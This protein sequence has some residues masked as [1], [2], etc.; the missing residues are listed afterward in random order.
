MPPA[1]QRLDAGDAPARNLDLGLVV[2]EKGAIVQGLPDILLERLAGPEFLVHRRVVEP[3]VVAALLLRL[4]ERQVG[5]PEELVGVGVVVRK[6]RD[7]DA[8]AREHLFLVEFERRRDRLDHPLGENGDAVLMVEVG[9]DDGELV[10][11]EPRHG[12]GLAHARQE[13]RGHL[14]Q[15]VVARR[16]SQRVVDVLEMV[17]VE[18]VDRHHPPGA[19]GVVERL[20]EPDLEVGAVGKLGEGVVVRAFPQRFLAFLAGF[21]HA[22]ERFGQDSY[23]VLG[24]D[25]DPVIELAFADG[26]RACDQFKN[27]PDETA[28]EH[29]RRADAND[30]AEQRHRQQE[31]HGKFDRT[32]RLPVGKASRHFGRL[33]FAAALLQDELGGTY[34]LCDVAVDSLGKQMR[35]GTRHEKEKEQNSDYQPY[36]FGNAGFRP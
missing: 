8:G 29:D 31:P 26:F 34:K 10:A 7:A 5:V 30:D 19:P 12:V 4:V 36:P 11:A 15:Q 21:G 18:V 28:G 27:R 6:H 33:G 24:I 13:A 35:D 16:V 2:E 3:V 17:E 20:V 25:R 23:F 9:L 32:R 1:S 14:F 22:V